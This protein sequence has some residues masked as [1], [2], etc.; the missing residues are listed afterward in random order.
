MVATQLLGSSF[1]WKQHESAI[2]SLARELDMPLTDISQV[3]ESALKELKSQS[4]ITNFLSIFA[5]RRVREL[6]SHK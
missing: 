1:E 3:Y 2:R 4:R 5:C 6:A